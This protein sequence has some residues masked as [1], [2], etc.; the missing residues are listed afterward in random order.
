MLGCILNLKMEVSHVV[1]IMWVTVSR[2]PL[3]LVFTLR[4]VS[5]LAVSQSAWSCV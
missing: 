4:S 2:F 5:Q 1:C 3:V